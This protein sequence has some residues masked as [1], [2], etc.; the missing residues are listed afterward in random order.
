MESR[1]GAGDPKITLSELAY[2]PVVMRRALAHPYLAVRGLARGNLP[3]GWDVVAFSLLFGTTILVILGTKQFGAPLSALEQSPVDLNPAA[4]PYYAL[5][6]TLRMM[7][8]MVLS[9]V[10]SLGYA[11]LALS[12]AAGTGGPR[13]TVTGEFRLGDVRHVFAST[14]SAERVLGFRARVGLAEGMR[15]FAAEELR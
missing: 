6:T 15:R 9:L 13:P 1:T 14:A 7:A 10:F 3:S 11:G 12:V 5:R 4:L 8:A 2:A